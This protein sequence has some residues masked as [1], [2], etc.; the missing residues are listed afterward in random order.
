MMSNSSRVVT[1]M[2]LWS[3]IGYIEDVINHDCRGA[4]GTEMCLLGSNKE[5]KGAGSIL[6]RGAPLRKGHQVPV[7]ATDCEIF[8]PLFQLLDFLLLCSS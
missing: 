1:Y 5:S 6:Q 4:G 2:T 7:K 3:P 8:P